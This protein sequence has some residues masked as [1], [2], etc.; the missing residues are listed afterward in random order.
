MQA[1]FGLYSLER[2]GEKVR[3]TDPALDGSERVL[4][5][6]LS[7]AHHFRV[8]R[9]IGLWCINFLRWPATVAVLSKLSPGGG[10]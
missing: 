9:Q 2:F 7:Q 4:H 5:G 10:P 8:L 6:L 3:G 1:H